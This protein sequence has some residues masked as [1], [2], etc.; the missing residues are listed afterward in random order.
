MFGGRFV[1]FLDKWFSVKRYWKGDLLIIIAIKPTP[2]LSQDNYRGKKRTNQNGKQKHVTGEKGGK[3]YTR[4]KRGK[5]CNW[6]KARE[7]L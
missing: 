2:K 1:I 4:K 6:R 3:T 7:N 5:T